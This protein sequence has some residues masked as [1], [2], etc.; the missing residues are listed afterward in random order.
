LTAI[1]ISEAELADRAGRIELLLLDVDGVLTDGGIYIDADG[2]DLKRFHV[3]DGSGIKY[4]QR[5][6]REVALLSGRSSP[7]VTARA[8][9]LGIARVFQ[10]AKAKEP[11]YER[12]LADAGLADSQVAVMGDDLPDL[13]LLRRAGLAIAPANAAEPVRAAADVVTAAGG[14]RGAVR[15]AVEMLL[16]SAGLWDRIMARYVEGT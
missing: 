13:P 5:V 11:V 9:E 7:A 10:N 6:G 12:I 14:G 8:A 1:H 16:K 2:R 15:E 3:A 4:F